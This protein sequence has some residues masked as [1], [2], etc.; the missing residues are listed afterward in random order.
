MNRFYTIFCSLLL[1]SFLNPAAGA[2][3]ITNITGTFQ[4][5][6]LTPPAGTI[7]TYLDY[8]AGNLTSGSECSLGECRFL[9]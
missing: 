4:N 1:V 3:Q 6:D 8:G 5:A 2:F 7:G 9:G